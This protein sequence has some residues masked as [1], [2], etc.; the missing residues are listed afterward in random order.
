MVNPEVNPQLFRSLLDR[1]EVATNRL[2]EIVEYQNDRY[3][4]GDE[5][6]FAQ[7]KGEIEKDVS[8][9]VIDDYNQLILEFVVP[10]IDLSEAIGTVVADQAKKVIDLFHAQELFL[11]VTLRSKKPNLET[12]EY[13][14][15]IKPMQ[16]ILENISDEREKARG[17]LL[18]NHLSMVSEGIVAL[19]WVTIDKTPCS[20]VEEI[21]N[22]AEFHGN[23][24]LKQ[25]KNDDPI[26]TQWVRSFMNILDGLYTYIKKNYVTGLT[27]NENGVECSEILKEQKNNNT[28]DLA[29]PPPPGPAPPPPPTPVPE[30]ASVDPKQTQGDMSD[31][32]KSLN[33]GVSIT[34]NL[35]KVDKSEMTHKNPTLRASSV[36]PSKEKPESPIVDTKNPT[37]TKKGPPVLALEG[38]KW[39]VEN[40]ENDNTLII[41]ETELSQSVAIF[42]CKNVTI[43]IKGKINGVSMSGCTKCN[44]I[45]DT[46]VSTVDISR[47]PSF[48]LQVLGSIPTVTADLCDGGMI[49]LSK[50]SLNT[51][52][53]SAKCSNLNVSIPDDE[54]VKELAVPEQFKS[55]IKDGQLVT[56]AV[57]FSG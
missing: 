56:T 12:S 4:N 21:K 57:E 16:D 30:A 27:W 31:V 13:R 33:Q 9:D 5:P 51:E 48:A 45:V 26:H 34:S 24:I 10:Y 40:Y 19:G 32:F 3:E 50:D 46:C 14:D 38:T 7:P 15:L 20:F 39:I 36:V 29:P 8:T 37:A 17:N 42:S 2:E 47:S 54:D 41:S 55:V 43:Q 35:R 23:R 53:W 25:Y 49:Y 11:K 28:N 22:S 18:F 6:I 44:I 1:L 52:V